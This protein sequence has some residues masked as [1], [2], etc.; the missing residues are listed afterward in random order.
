MCRLCGRETC[1]ECF[2]QVKDLTEDRPGATPGDIAALQAR[3]EKHSHSNP[4]F[5]ACTRRNEH[6]S[7]EFSPMSRFCKAELSEAINEMQA[8]V[9]TP[10]GDALP[11]EVLAKPREEFTDGNAFVGIGLTFND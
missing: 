7:K 4:F 6:Q 1:S 3:R 8:L 10:D 2:A 11:T 5:L 9:D